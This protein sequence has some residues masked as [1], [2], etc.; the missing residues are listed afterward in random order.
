MRSRCLSAIVWSLWILYFAVSLA[1]AQ[2]TTPELLELRGKVINSV[3]GEP[4]AGALVQISSPGQKVQFTGADGTFD[5]PDLPPGNYSPFARKPGFFND[6]ERGIPSGPLLVPAGQSEEVILKLAPEAIIYG[7]VKGGSGLPLEGATVR[8]QRWQVE[9]G[10]RRLVPDGN[11]VTDDEGNFRLSGLRPGRYYLSFPSANSRG[12]YRFN[13]LSS[14]K[15]LEEGYG[16]QFYPGVPDLE[17]ASV[18]EIHAGAQVHIVQ[19]LTRQ[20]L[21]EVAGVVR[22]GDPE[23]GFNLMLTNAT[24]DVAQRSVRINPKTGQFQILGVPEGTYLLRANGNQRPLLTKTASGLL[25]IADEDRP[26]LTAALR[27]PVHNNLSGV[28]VVLGSGVSIGVQIRDEI[29]DYEGANNLH[30]VSL[31]MT[32]QEFPLGSSWI[33]VPRAPGDR[34]APTRFEGLAPDTYTVSGTPN[35]P[36]YISS[37]RCGSVDLLRD[38][39][40]VASGAAQP[41]IEVTLRDDGAQLNVKVV[42]NGQ[43]VAAGILLFSREYPRR[44]QFFGSADSLSVGN[45]APGTYYVIAMRSA[46]SVEFRNPAVMEQYLGHATEV[47]LG[48]RANVSVVAEVQEQEGAAQ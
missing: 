22:G 8:A 4:I 9:N 21:F 23:N 32:P 38:D 11:A 45:L 46:E 24:G 26:P 12:W 14:R 6:S 18:I 41:P 28:V 7:E 36:W 43:P 16:A 19:T 40:T 48:P 35:G 47:T 31:E 33:T 42:K 37:M 30:Q 13:Q 39:L 1:S 15:H 29:S 5:F 2:Q 10:Q 3:T 44:S 17:S 20:S 34:R 25:A 27:L